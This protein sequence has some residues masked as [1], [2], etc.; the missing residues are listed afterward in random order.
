MSSWKQR[1][2]MEL[3]YLVEQG[4]NAMNRDTGKFAEVYREL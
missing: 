1:C 4:N 3:M 2:F